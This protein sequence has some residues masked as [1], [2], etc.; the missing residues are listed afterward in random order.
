MLNYFTRFPE[1][2][3]ESD[4]RIA[5]RT[6]PDLTILECWGKNTAFYPRLSIL[7]KKYLA[8]PASYVPSE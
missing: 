2:Q 3:S 4:S 7:A 5:V 6:Y 8:I 1:N